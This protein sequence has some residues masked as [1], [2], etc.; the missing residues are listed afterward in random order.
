MVTFL[1][2]FTIVE[3]IPIFYG[4]LNLLFIVV[5]FFSL[6]FSGPTGFFTA[7]LLGVL[8]DSICSTTFGLFLFAYMLIFITIYFIKDKFHTHNLLSQLIL[9]FITFLIFKLVTNWTIFLVEVNFSTKELIFKFLSQLGYLLLF[10][11]IIFFI[12]S[13]INK[14]KI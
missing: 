2:Q 8:H 4:N 11:P 12:L 9:V 13:R 3:N 14:D 1:L 10:S 6:F 7:M 5:V